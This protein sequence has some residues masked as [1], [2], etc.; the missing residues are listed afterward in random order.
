[1]NSLSRLDIKQIR[2]LIALIEL[3]SLSQVAKKMGLTQQAI[4]EQLR[5]LRDT[6]DDLLFIRQGNKMVPTTKALSL[7]V[8]AQ[9]V[10]NK[11]EDMLAPDEF[12]PSEFEGIFTISATDYAIHALLPK[13]MNRLRTDAPGLKII[14][15]DFESDDVNELLSSGELDLLLSFPEFIPES[16]PYKKL[17]CEQHVCIVSKHSNLLEQNVSL[18]DIAHR[19]QIIVSPSRANLRGSLEQWFNTFGLKRH[20]VMAVPSF[21]SVPE[22]LHATDMIAFYPSRLLPNEKVAILDVGYSPPPFEVI[23]GWHPRTSQSK[24]HQWIINQLEC[25]SSEHCLKV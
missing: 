16:L 14:V 22:I 1:M 24:I 17:F 7:Q 9:E 5:K 4:S 12:N 23:V 19:P 3:K 6:F 10:L 15:R 18:E 20:I 13:L 25:I 2:I 8:P 21:S 11:I